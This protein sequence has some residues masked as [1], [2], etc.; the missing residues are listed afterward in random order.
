M[1]DTTQVY[2]KKDG[3]ILMMYRNVKEGDISKGKWIGIGG[4]C[5]KDE[6]PKDCATRETLEETGI[7]LNILNKVGEVEFIN[8]VYEDELIHI[9]VSDDF[10]KVT[11]PVSYE[12]ELEWISEDE[13]MDLNLW[14]GDRLFMPKVIEGGEFFKMRLL[15][16]RDKLIGIGE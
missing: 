4:K 3:R 11:E 15:Y 6:E 10:E 1:M 12:G 2:L 14:E 8:T 16:D 9:Y 13:I 7:N 5:E